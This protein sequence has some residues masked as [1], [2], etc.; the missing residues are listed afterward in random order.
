MA[1]K[2]TEDCINCGACE[3]ECPNQ[4]ISAGDERYEINPEKCTECVGYFNEPQ[5][6]SVCPVNC[7]IPDPD[8][9]ETREE[10]EAKF[11]KL[12]SNS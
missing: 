8:H 3:P 12:K 6:A 10:L 9:R 1:Y 5:C 4:A 11:N 7:C 2:I